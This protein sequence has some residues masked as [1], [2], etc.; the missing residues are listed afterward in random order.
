MWR[1]PNT[2]LLMLITVV[3]WFQQYITVIYLLIRE[4]VLCAEYWV[5]NEIIGNIHMLSLSRDNV[6]FDKSFKFKV[7]SRRH[8][9]AFCLKKSQKHDNTFH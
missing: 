1:H 6:V 7:V 5:L 2:D 8:I 4:L 9:L 3:T